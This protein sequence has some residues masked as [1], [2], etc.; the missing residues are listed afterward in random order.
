MAVKWSW[1][2]GPETGTQLNNEMGW[3]CSTDGNRVEPTQAYTYTYPGSPT[4]GPSARYSLRSDPDQW[5]YIP[6]SAWSPEGWV[7]VPYY[8]TVAGIHSYGRLINVYGALENNS[9]WVDFRVTDEVELF[10]D[11]VSQGSVVLSGMT[12]EWNYWAL[13]Y[14][15]L[16][17]T[18]GA[19]LF[20]NG[21]EIL[22]G[23]ETG[24][25]AETGGIISWSGPGNGDRANYYGQ[26]ICYDSLSDVGA[27]EPFQYV[28]RVNP[29]VDTSETGVWTP[30]VGSDEFAVLSASYNSS[31]LT[32]NTGSS[33]GDKVICQAQNLA[34][35]LGT[36]PSTIPGITSHCW[37]SGSGQNGFT[38]LS[39]DNATYD[40][41]TEITPDTNDPTYCFS[42]APD[43][44]SNGA[45]WHATSSLYIK[46]EV[47]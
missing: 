45:V 8:K 42:T 30:S 22:S 21:V 26:I 40:N 6:N 13:R 16:G 24:K 38:A 10:I 29:T 9:I 5:V 33:T 31:T 32:S 2:F 12:N 23:S 44:P 47:S 17:T 1:A 7:A 39:D 34:T 3:V 25:A 35:Q 19:T 46:Y 36:V 15:M 27:K 20:L 11:S 14:T 37:A 43:Q 18:W 28:T 4:T 41:G